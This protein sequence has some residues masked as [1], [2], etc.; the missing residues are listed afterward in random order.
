MLKARAASTR[1]SE[2]VGFANALAFVAAL[3]LTLTGCGRSVDEPHVVLYVSADE[4]LARQM[5]REFHG[6]TGIRVDLVSDVEAKKPRA[7]FSDSGPNATTPKRMC[8]GRP[9][10]L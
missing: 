8:S 2:N 7:W 6:Q 10:S 4:H 1:G 5:I 9:R 3:L